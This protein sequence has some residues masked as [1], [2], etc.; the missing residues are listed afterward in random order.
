MSHDIELLFP[1][2][3][4]RV[5]AL[6]RDQGSVAYQSNVHSQVVQLISLDS[7]LSA[8]IRLGILEPMDVLTCL[9]QHGFPSL[10]VIHLSTV[11]DSSE[12]EI[13]QIR[14]IFLNTTMST[15][16][17]LASK[18]KHVERKHADLRYELRLSCHFST[19]IP[20]PNDA[21]TEIP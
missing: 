14:R 21:Q 10:H 8:T 18:G 20:I 12:C 15:V 5:R 11:S 1:P 19:G 9:L 2:G 3:L 16:R 7:F 6:L 4:Y 17:V 13:Q